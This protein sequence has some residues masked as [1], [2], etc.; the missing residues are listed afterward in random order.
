MRSNGL[1]KRIREARDLL[2]KTQSEFAHSI[3]TF[4]PS[5]S[6]WE[7]GATTPGSALLAAIAKK[8]KI[9]LNWLLIGVG[10]KTR[11]SPSSGQ[12]VR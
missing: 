7:K 10:S 8:H 2:G 3:G 9:N 4:Q 5:V 1:A 12:R 6:S 11:R